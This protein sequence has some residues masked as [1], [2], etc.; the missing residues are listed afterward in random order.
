MASARRPR[1]LA[2][3]S[4]V[5]VAVVLASATLAAL[6]VALGGDDE[7]PGG[8]GAGRVVRVVDGDTV[9][10]DVAGSDEHVRLLGI[11]TPESVDPRSPVE[12]FG[13]EA[14]ARTAALLPPGAE[15]RLVRDVEARD[16]YARL[17]AYVYRID[18]GSFVNLVLVEE[19]Y[20]AP[21]TYPP[22]V[23]HAG[24]ITAAAA[25]ARHAGRGLWAAC[26][27]P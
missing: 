15:V 27:A 14:A 13:T 9:V 1:R 3:P 5:A 2:A 20:A 26:R 11:D 18:D 17:L 6:A 25:R 10:V 23:A 24:E 12:C 21:L 8:A 16:R 22:N 7:P 19:G 4:A